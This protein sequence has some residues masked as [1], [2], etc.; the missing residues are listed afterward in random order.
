MSEKCRNKHKTN[1]NSDKPLT[2]RR[3]DGGKNNADQFLPQEK[4]LDLFSAGKQAQR[5]VTRRSYEK[6]LD[7][8]LSSLFCPF[9]SCSE[10]VRGTGEHISTSNLAYVRVIIHFFQPL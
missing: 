9:K 8:V 5:N 2:S 7:F 1:N 10:T 6:T 4:C 3:T